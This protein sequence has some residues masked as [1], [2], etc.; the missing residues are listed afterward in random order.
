MPSRKLSVV[1]RTPDPAITRLVDEYFTSCRAG[2]LSP[3]TINE[4]YGYPL[5][6]VFLRRASPSPLT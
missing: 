3:K 2:G 5:R 1:P 4:G 6:G